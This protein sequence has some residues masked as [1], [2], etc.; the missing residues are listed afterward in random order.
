MHIIISFVCI[1]ILILIFLAIKDKKLYKSLTKKPDCH[2]QSTTQT[3]TELNSKL[4]RSDAS[5]LKDYREYHMTITERF[6]SSCML[7]VPFFLIGYIFFQNAIIAL[8]ISAIGLFFLKTRKNYVINQRAKQ[9]KVQFKHAMSCLASS[10]SAGTSIESAFQDAYQDLSLLYPDD[11]SYIRVE[12]QIIMRR[13][14]N[15]EAIETAII[16]F[17]Q[18]SGLDDALRFADVFAT[19]KRTGGNLI[20]VMKRTSLI[21]SE[22]LEIDQEIQVLISQKKFESRILA[23]TPFIIISLLVM[24]SP[25]YM[26]PLY[27]GFGILIM[28][29]CLIILIS[30]F[31]WTQKIMQIEV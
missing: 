4:A 20:D 18:R 19:V 28:A 31:L 13:L 25:D 6:F 1:S 26:A 11:Q 21:I 17:A 22:K 15:G 7:M 3:Q 2:L 29:I 30:C 23:V 5:P 8:S 12:F 10:L 14:D 27:Q 24:T 16:N 9:L